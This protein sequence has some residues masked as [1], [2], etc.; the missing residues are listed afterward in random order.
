MHKI[1]LVKFSDLQV[2]NAA[3]IL[4]ARPKSKVAQ[5]NMD[6]F[7]DAWINQ[8]WDPAV[9][10]FVLCQVSCW[11]IRKRI[12]LLWFLDSWAEW[13]YTKSTCSYT[14]NPRLCRIC[15]NVLVARI[16]CQLTCL[17]KLAKLWCTWL[18]AGFYVGRSFRISIELPGPHLDRRRRRHHHRRRLLGRVRKPHPWGCQWLRCSPSGWLNKAPSVM[19]APNS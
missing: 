8:V 13:G 17:F 11:N 3:R 4:A 19:L 9:P 10:G 14:S 2:I 1:I 12:I 15:V 6:V 18:V 5:E 16:P 7:K